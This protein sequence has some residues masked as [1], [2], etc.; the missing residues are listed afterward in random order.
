MG[1]LRPCPRHPDG[2]LWRSTTLRG[3]TG[4]PRLDD[5]LGLVVALA[6]ML[7]TGGV[8]LVASVAVVLAAVGPPRR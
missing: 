6:T 3:S 2:T 8:A 1:A 7:V 4:W 5:V